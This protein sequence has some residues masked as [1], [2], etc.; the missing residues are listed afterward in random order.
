MKKVKNAIIFCPEKL[1][2]IKRLIW[3][4]ETEEFH[5]LCDFSQTGYFYVKIF[6]IKEYIDI[7]KDKYF[8]NDNINK[9]YV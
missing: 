1:E 5:I 2:K 7:P 4:K 9:I 8:L 3:V 6:S